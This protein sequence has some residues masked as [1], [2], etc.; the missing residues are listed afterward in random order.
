MR[1]ERYWESFPVGDLSVLDTDLALQ[2]AADPDP[3]FNSQISIP[4]P[5]VLQLDA[6]SSA[7][8]SDE[9]HSKTHSTGKQP[10]SIALNSESVSANSL[11]TTLPPLSIQD[12]PKSV[13]DTEQTRVIELQPNRT[14]SLTKGHLI[15]GLGEFAVSPLGQF[16]SMEQKYSRS[17]SERALAIE[18]SR[19]GTQSPGLRQD[20]LSVFRFPNE[21]HWPLGRNSRDILP[22]V[23]AG[24][25]TGFEGPFRQIN[26]FV[27]KDPDSSAAAHEP[28]LV[29]QAS[30]SLAG[31]DRAGSE[32]QPNLPID[33]KNESVQN[34]SADFVTELKPIEKDIDSR[35]LPLDENFDSTTFQPDHVAAKP[36]SANTRSDGGPKAVLNAKDF[37]MAEQPKLGASYKEDHPQRDKRA[38][39]VEPSVHDFSPDPID[40]YQ[41]Y[42]PG[43]NMHVYQ[44]KQLYA[45]QRPLVELGRPWYQLGQLSPPSTIFG[46]HNPVTPQ[47]LIFGD[48]RTAYATA[49]QD[50]DSTS[51]IAWELNLFWNLQ[52]TSTERFHMFVA[53]VDDGA[54]KNTRDLL[55]EDLFV[56]EFDFDIDFGYFEG[57]L[58]AI[59]GG[60]T[61]ETLPFDLPFTLGIIP[62][63]VQNGVWMED[64]FLGMAMTI[65]ARN[66]ARFDISNMDF[67]FFAGFDQINSDAFAGEDD[68]AKMW[69]FLSFIEAMNGYWEID[70]AFLED[71]TARDRSY[72]NIGIGFT[73]RYGRF[74][75]N[76]TRM[77]VN[78]GQS[79]IAGPNT[80]DG[81][82]LLSENSLISGAPSSIVP[83]FNAWIGFDRPQSASRAAA[84]GGVLRNTG[85]L[86]E[87]DGMTGFPTL[88]PTAN[89]TY[90]GA[91]GINILPNDFSQQLVLEM[92]ALGV[93]GEDSVRNAQGD[94]Y[95]VGFRYQLP[96]SNS[97]IFRT[98]GIY[99][100]LRGD[101]DAHGLRMELRRKF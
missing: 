66:S 20:E 79:T 78:A 5:V 7:N 1:N 97:L 61:G 63:L 99:G 49:T 74:L 50:G 51:Q 23:L 76:S 87:S 64:A 96:L 24:R 18:E 17:H 94:Q 62:L 12:Q 42:D 31:F 6:Q 86:F 91:L 4:D 90:G 53:P 13:F 67:T 10:R 88:D 41:P 56:E 65:P 9:L 3:E 48:F 82:L 80:A 19:P 33:P 73:R 37:L 27:R 16:G 47:F 71:R 55:D 40:P 69:G 2:P 70:Y 95:G 39:E 58:G 28:K 92:A 38:Y 30:A 93:M 22:K 59:V 36:A 54:Q 35:R 89:D 11:A 15:E 45:N 81:V 25:R 98:D 8:G 68:A 46:A 84:A 34:S 77:I 85:I 83:Y 60:C 26:P 100:F 14:A 43:R 101:E 44:G 75:S 32:F 52:L 21:Q 57:D 72:H 29:K